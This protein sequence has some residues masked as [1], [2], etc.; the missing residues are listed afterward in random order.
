MEHMR[1]KYTIV[2]GPGSSLENAKEYSRILTKFIYDNHCKSLL[3]LGRGHLN[4]IHK[5]NCIMIMS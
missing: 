3:D 2:I 5:T 4:W 1:S